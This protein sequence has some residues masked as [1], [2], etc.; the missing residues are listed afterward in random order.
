MNR[1]SLAALAAFS[2]AAGLCTSTAYSAT[3]TAAA[4]SASAD[5]G[6]LHGRLT[7]RDGASYQGRLR[8]DDEEA[9]GATGPL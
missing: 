9:A 1:T 4:A 6:Y 7:T 3:A 8:G 2:L 5:A